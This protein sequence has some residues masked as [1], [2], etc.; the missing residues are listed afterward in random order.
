MVMVLPQR[1]LLLKYGDIDPGCRLVIPGHLDPIRE[2]YILVQH[3]FEQRE[4]AA[5]IITR[6]DFVELRPEQSEQR[7]AI[8]RLPRR[9][10]VGQQGQRPGAAQRDYLSVELDARRAE[11][12]YAQHAIP[13]E[14]AEHGRRVR[15]IA[16]LGE[17]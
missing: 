7:L 12:N 13:Q 8:L 2:Q 9:R 4:L 15:T 14:R 10:Q 11:E 6:A 3:G 1:D 5:Q 17:T 16:G